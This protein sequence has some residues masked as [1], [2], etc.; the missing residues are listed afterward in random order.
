MYP[1]RPCFDM[2]GAE[3]KENDNGNECEALEDVGNKED[4]VGSQLCDGT[5]LLLQYVI[6]DFV[7]R[8]PL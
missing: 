6:R 4:A 7:V 1:L 3:R 2:I 8:Y 5:V